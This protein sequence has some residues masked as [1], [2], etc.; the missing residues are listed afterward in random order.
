MRL[1]VQRHPDNDRQRKQAARTFMCQFLE[2]D[3]EALESRGGE[4]V[5]VQVC[6]SQLLTPSKHS[7]CKRGGGGETLKRC[8]IFLSL[9]KVKRWFG[10]NAGMAHD[11]GALPGISCFMAAER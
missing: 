1:G 5:R 9:I 8:A 6:G 2:E 4:L 11:A 3:P 7:I 10:L